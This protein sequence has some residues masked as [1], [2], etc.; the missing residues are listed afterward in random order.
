MGKLKNK[1]KFEKD[2]KVR[3][4]RY[5]VCYTAYLPLPQYIVRIRDSKTTIANIGNRP[6][7]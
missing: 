3:H 2:E 5:A 1:T 7:L 6:Q 4:V